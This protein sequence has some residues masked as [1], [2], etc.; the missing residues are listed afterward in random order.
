M[1]PSPLVTVGVVTGRP[2]CWPFLRWNLERIERRDPTF[3]TEVIVVATPPAYASTLALE[4][5]DARVYPMGP[6]APVGSMRNVVLDRARGDYLVW[7]D[8]DD[9][10]HPR[11]IPWL[12]DEARRSGA[13]ITGW[14]RGWLLDL[15]T[16]W[17]QAVPSG[18]R[19]INGAAIYKLPD[20]WCEE[21][22]AGARASDA[23][24]LQRLYARNL[25]VKHLLDDRIHALW[26][27]HRSNVSP[28]TYGRF[29]IPFNQISQRL[30]S[31]AADLSERLLE[32]RKVLA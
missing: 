2:A 14:V 30:G 32:L 20:V 17:A 5:A 29:D 16:F 31:D 26:T 25:T 1:S 24:W 22:D 15:D 27:R 23:R 28:V 7:M 10:Y 3:R 4:M 18:K 8:D 11:R 13:A 19:V 12:L 21:Y 9:W 6:D